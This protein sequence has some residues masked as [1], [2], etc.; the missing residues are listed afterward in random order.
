MRIADKREI[1][2]SISTTTDG[3]M[4]IPYVPRKCT[5]AAT[6]CAYSVSISLFHSILFHSVGWWL[7]GGWP[8]KRST[9]CWPAVTK[10][11]IAYKFVGREASCNKR[12]LGEKEIALLFLC[13]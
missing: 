7:V 5:P 4:D 10:K 2:P 1:S 8:L 6:A 11:I 12:P 13:R 9:H 3:W